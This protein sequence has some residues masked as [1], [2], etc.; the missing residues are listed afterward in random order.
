MDK[1]DK[2]ILIALLIATIKNIIIVALFIFLA[3]FF[4]KWWLS[5]FSIFFWS[6]DKVES[7]KIRKIRLGVN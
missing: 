3:I 6:G 5:L 4:N 7:K 1:G 2:A